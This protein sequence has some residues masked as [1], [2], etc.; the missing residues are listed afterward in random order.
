[1][2][3]PGHNLSTKIVVQQGAASNW[4]VQSA[5]LHADS[6]VLPVVLLDSEIVDVS[7]TVGP[8]TCVVNCTSGRNRSTVSNTSPEPCQMRWKPSQRLVTSHG[9]HTALV[10]ACCRAAGC[11]V[12]R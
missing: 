1:M 9:A 6:A 10:A 5:S 7:I 4:Q 3:M 8:G 12:Y 11:A 2:R